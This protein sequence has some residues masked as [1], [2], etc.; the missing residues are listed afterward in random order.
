MDGRQIRVEKTQGVRWLDYPHPGRTL[1]LG[2]LVAKGLHSCPMNFWPEMVFGVIAVI[3]PGPVVQFVIG[4]HAPRNRLIRIAAIVA[5]VTVQIREAVAK[6][7]EW[8]KKTDVMPIKNAENNE[9]RDE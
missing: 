2:N 8:Q 1:L 3:E 7:P 9:G 4:A 5:I 6:V